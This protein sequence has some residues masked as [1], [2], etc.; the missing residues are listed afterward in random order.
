[1]SYVTDYPAAA[2]D[3]A[4]A[5]YLH[6]LSLE[7]DCAD[8]NAAIQSGETDFVIL[9]V[10]GTEQTFSH[11]HIPGAIHL[12]HRFIT[13]DRMAEW[14][15]DTLFVVYCAGP[16]CNGADQAALKLARLGRPVKVMPGGIT[17]WEDEKLAFA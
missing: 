9:H 16:H 12:P 15:L 3:I 13:A 14:P 5:H 7:T 6:K 2:P 8:V 11:R 10:V 4:A 1:M 17:G